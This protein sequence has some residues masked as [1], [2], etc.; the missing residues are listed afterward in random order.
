LDDAGIS[1]YVDSLLYFSKYK[2]MVFTYNSL[3]LGS[4]LKERIAVIKTVHGNKWGRL[5]TII[6][7]MIICFVFFFAKAD[8]SKGATVYD[9]YS[10][11]DQIIATEYYPDGYTGYC[12]L[13][14]PRMSNWPYGNFIEIYLICQI[15]ENVLKEMSTDELVQTVV[16]YPLWSDVFLYNSKKEGYQA[17]KS[18]FNGLAELCLRKDAYDSLMNQE[19]NMEEKYPVAYNVLMKYLQDEMS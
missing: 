15:P 18:K 6:G 7:I 3:F 12:Y 13:S 1:D 9:K 17:I 2:N 16:A 10:E 14:L 19:N 8:S 5:L 4:K 11:E